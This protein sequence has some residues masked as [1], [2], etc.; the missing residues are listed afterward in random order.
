MMF[1]PATQYAILALSFLA[2]LPDNAP[3]N[4]KTI[5][6]E[7]GVPDP[8]LAKILTQLKLAR[9]VRANKGPGGGYR[10]AKPAD[11]ICLADILQA[12]AGQDLF[13]DGCVLGLDRCQDQHPCPLHVEWKK[14]KTELRDKFH[15]ITLEELGEKLV[16][17]RAHLKH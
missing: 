15:S 1:S 17:K 12:V 8:F 2:S 9:I 11:E 13:A 6:T 10:L 7:A 5:A 3:R 14:F 4:V 16:E